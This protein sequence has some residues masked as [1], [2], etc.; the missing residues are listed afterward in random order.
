M[1]STLECKA[2]V[3]DT[4]YKLTRTGKELIP[5]IGYLNEWVEIQM[6]KENLLQKEC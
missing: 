3:F 6:D 4:E 1:E 2:N 5:F